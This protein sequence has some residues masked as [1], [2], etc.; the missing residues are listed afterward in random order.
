MGKFISFFLIEALISEKYTKSLFLAL[1]KDTYSIIKSTLL[2]KQPFHR[3]DGN[4]YT[5]LRLL[6]VWLGC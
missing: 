2:D 1:L 6:Y 3:L 4:E 5:T